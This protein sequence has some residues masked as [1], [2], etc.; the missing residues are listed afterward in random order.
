MFSCPTVSH[1]YKTILTATYTGGPGTIYVY[2][3]NT[4]NFAKLAVTAGL[5][6]DDVKAD[7]SAVFYTNGNQVLCLM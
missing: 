2:T 4:M 6:I 1:P 7:D 5:G 3:N